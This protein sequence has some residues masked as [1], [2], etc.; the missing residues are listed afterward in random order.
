IFW[1]ACGGR[2]R[3]QAPQRRYRCARTD[4]VFA[5]TPCRQ[6]ADMP[7]VDNHVLN[8]VGSLLERVMTDPKI[9]AALK[10]MWTKHQAQPDHK[11]T[12]PKLQARIDTARASIDSATTC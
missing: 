7:Q 5:G 2:M 9:Q 6:T 8:Q 10:R 1:P 12:A 11:D 3:G 4:G